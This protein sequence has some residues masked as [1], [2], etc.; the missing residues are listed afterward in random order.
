MVIPYC[1]DLVNN[2]DGSAT[3][4]LRL[5]VNTWSIACFLDDSDTQVRGPDRTHLIF[6]GFPPRSAMKSLTSSMLSLYSR[7]VC[8]LCSLSFWVEVLF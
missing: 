8:C 2:L 6:S 1:D 5:P 7:P 3:A 4:A